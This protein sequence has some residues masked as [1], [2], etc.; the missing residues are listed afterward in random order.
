MGA[1]ITAIILG[2]VLLT[3]WLLPRL[4]LLTN[5][6]VSFT[7]ENALTTGPRLI[8]KVPKTFYKFEFWRSH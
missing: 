6:P 7:A 8:H 4:P 1:V 5:I 2:L 3:G